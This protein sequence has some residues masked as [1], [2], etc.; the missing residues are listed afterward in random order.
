VAASLLDI[1][2]TGGQP[3]IVRLALEHL[4]WTPNDARWHGNLMRPLGEHPEA[5]RVRYR[6]KN[7]HSDVVPCPSV[8]CVKEAVRP[9]ILKLSEPAKVSGSV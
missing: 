2:A 8:R 1:G 3:E 6:Y 9:A 7:R 4:D 5:D